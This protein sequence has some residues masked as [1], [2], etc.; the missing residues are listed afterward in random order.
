MKKRLL[1]WVV[2]ALL[3]TVAQAQELNCNVTI[4]ADKI[5]GSSKEVY[6]TL[7]QAI[8][9]YMNTNKW[10]NLTYGPTERIDCNL[11]ILVN[12]VGENNEY[13][14]EAT[15]QAS[16]P[17]FNTT[18]TT[19]L[20]NIKDKEF[21]FTYN[22][23]QLTYQQ[24]TF[25]TNLSAMLAYYVYLILGVDADSYARL[26]GTPY[27]QA[28]ENIVSVCQTASGLT[29]A[30]MSGWQYS[31]RGSGFQATGRRYVTVNEL[32]DE[33]FKPYRN[34]FYEYHRLCLDEM[35]A[36]VAN[37][38]ARIAE[39]LP[40]LRDINKNRSSNIIIPIFLDTKVDELV[41]I[42]HGGTPK[43]KT[44]VYDLLMALDPT[45]TNTYDLITRED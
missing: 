14:C 28:C 23:E 25:T 27:F 7:K 36:N 21:N 24:S 41:N 11:M 34:F 35:Q 45:R 39:G 44:D 19:N 9:E 38:R 33:N 30:E 4:N 42:F 18:Y 1:I 29:E 5:E 2:A 3:G 40:V 13:M 6:E 17:V 32:M 26:G 10:T 20:L 12:S 43:E 16:R 8:S 37:A 31:R 15:I 22:Y